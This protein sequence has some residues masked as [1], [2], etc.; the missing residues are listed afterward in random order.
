LEESVVIV[1][2]AAEEEEAM[3]CLINIESVNLNTV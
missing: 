2:A 1:L 3:T